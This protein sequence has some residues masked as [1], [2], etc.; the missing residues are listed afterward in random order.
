MGLPFEIP[1]EFK[2]TGSKAK[3]WSKELIPS[4]DTLLWRYR[5]WSQFGLTRRDPE[6]MRSLRLLFGSYGSGADWLLRAL[7]HFDHSMPCFYAP[8]ERIDPLLISEGHRWVLPLD[9]RKELDGTHPLEHLL[10]H[11]AVPKGK[12]LQR[13]LHKQVD[14]EQID[15]NRIMVYEPNAMLMT[16]ALV[17]TYHIPMILMATD[18]VYCV[19]RY[20]AT[21]VDER[22]GY[23]QDEF[24]AVKDTAF[25]LRFFK[26]DT[27]K[28]RKAHKMIRS[29][30]DEH[31]RRLFSMVLTLGV[32]HRM[33]RHLSVK[34]HLIH[35]VSLSDFLHDTGLL[36]KLVKIYCNE[37]DKKL[38]AG[39]SNHDYEFSSD[40]LMPDLNRRPRILDR[41]DVKQAYRYLSLA[42]LS[43]P[44]KLLA[45]GG[46]RHLRNKAA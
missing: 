28:I 25:L 3:I 41:S 13:S 22:A 44:N 4:I 12:L 37:P 16:E 14:Q 18:P 7:S 36:R 29:M 46:S 31:D 33:F 20:M 45:T 15:F 5:L 27:A 40:V 1:I 26:K 17:R 35:C 32:M 42:G 9:Y 2:R 34:Y 43:E 19:D 39:M 6:A 30:G 24:E 23:L 11:L 10:Q 21:E 8:S 38:L